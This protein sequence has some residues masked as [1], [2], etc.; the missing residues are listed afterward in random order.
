MHG[1][2]VASYD[3][4]MPDVSIAIAM[5]STVEYLEGY[6]TYDEICLTLKFLQITI[7]I[8]LIESDHD[9]NST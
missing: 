7:T 1:A 2:G 6:C 8:V 5:Y 3:I 9:H 4:R